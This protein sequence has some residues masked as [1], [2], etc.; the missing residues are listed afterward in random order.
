M[1]RDVHQ[2]ARRRT[3]FSDRLRQL[4]VQ[5]GHGLVPDRLVDQ[6]NSVDGAPW[7]TAQTF[8]NWLNGVQLP[9]TATLHALAEWLHVTP[10]YLAD[11]TPV[12]HFA[13]AK[14]PDIDTTQLVDHFVQLDPAGRRAALAVMAALVQLEAEAA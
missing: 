3:A 11:G 2:L 12:L 6:L 8:S 5:R 10:E 7:V 1:T 13:P 14:Y 9:R 4:L